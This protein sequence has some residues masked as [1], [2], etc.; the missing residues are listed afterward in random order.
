MKKK[1][2]RKSLE[3]KI[4]LTEKKIFVIPVKKKK[5]VSRN[6]LYLGTSAHQN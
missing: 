2:M 4:P 6:K 5:L 3:K 1:F